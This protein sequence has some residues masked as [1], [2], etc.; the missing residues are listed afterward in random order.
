MPSYRTDLGRARGLGAA[1]HG[2]GGF[3]VERVTAIALIPLTLWAVYSGL[4]LS[5]ADYNGAVIWLRSPVN[6]VLLSLLLWIGFWHARVGLRVVVEDYVHKPLGKSVL[7]LANMFISIGGAVL[8][9][10]CVLKVAFGGA[11]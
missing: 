4:I 2:V 10:F 8:A 5:L 9:I 3:I 1:K 11:F 6:A 7:L